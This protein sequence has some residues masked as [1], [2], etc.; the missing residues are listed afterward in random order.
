[1]FQINIV[2]VFCL[3]CVDVLPQTGND[4]NR[5]LLAPC[6]YA[7]QY[8]SIFLLQVLTLSKSQYLLLTETS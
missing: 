7:E 3:Y 2:T 6:I 4:Y 1:M 8:V 5:L